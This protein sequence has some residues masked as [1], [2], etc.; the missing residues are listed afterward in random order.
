MGAVF[1][2]CDERHLI[3]V[4]YSVEDLHL[5]AD[6]LNI[7]KCWY[8][9]GRRPHYDIPKHRIKE[10]HAKCNVVSGRELVRMMKAYDP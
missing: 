7:K 9:G 5:M 2:F 3:C 10:I 1:Y 8:H 4:P 6:T